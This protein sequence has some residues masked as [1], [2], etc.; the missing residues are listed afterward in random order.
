MKELST[1][2]PPSPPLES[3]SYDQSHAAQFGLIVLERTAVRADEHQVGGDVPFFGEL[4]NHVRTEG[5]F[6]Q[7][8]LDIGVGVG[9]VEKLDVLRELGTEHRRSSGRP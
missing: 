9:F 1:C 5:S 2:M 6:D 7:H 4:L 3:T 8:E